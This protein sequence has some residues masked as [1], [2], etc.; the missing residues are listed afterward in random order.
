[1]VFSKKILFSQSVSSAS[2]SMV[3][4]AMLTFSALPHAR[5]DKECPN[6]NIQLVPLDAKFGTVLPCDAASN[7]RRLARPCRN[8]L[9]NRARDF[10][11]IA[12]TGEV[13]LEFAV[14]VQSQ[15]RIKLRPQ[16]H[17]AHVNR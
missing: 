15:G 12:K 6:R 1:M 13:I 4:L 7:C 14:Q 2:I 17:V 5:R 10:L 16:D 11:Q 8:L 3:C 9:E